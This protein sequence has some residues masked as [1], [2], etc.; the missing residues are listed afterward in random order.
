MARTTAEEKTITKHRVLGK[1]F[2][3]SIT[4]TALPKK[5]NVSAGAPTIRSFT[6]FRLIIEGSTN[7]FLQTPADNS[8]PV[9]DLQTAHHPP[10]VV[11]FLAHYLLLFLEFP[12]DFLFLLCVF[13]VDRLFLFNFPADK[14]LLFFEFPTNILD[15]LVEFPSDCL[16]L[17]F[18][19]LADRLFLLLA[20][21]GNC[22]LVFFIFF[23]VPTQGMVVDYKNSSDF[24]L[25]AMGERTVN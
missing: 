15:L 11:I 16:H 6:L 10:T 20:F 12:A 17:F 21:S 5:Y 24:L 7:T 13:P 3:T 9:L 4:L 2:K 25:D 22:L 18:V 8:H 1:Y 19:F 23:L 14:L